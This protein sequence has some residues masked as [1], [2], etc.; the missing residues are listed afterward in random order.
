MRLGYDFRTYVF[1]YMDRALKAGRPAW[2]RWLELSYSLRHKYAEAIEGAKKPE[3]RTR[4]IEA[5]VRAIR[6]RPER[7][8]YQ[9]ATKR[10]T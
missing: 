6:A 9:L 5:A 7:K 10:L 1:P 3:T 2:H 4:R 8:Y